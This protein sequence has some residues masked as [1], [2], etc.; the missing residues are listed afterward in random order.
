MDIPKEVK[1]IL[2][3][4]EKTKYEAFIVGGCVR[5]LIMKREPQDWDITTNAPPEEVKKIFP[6]SFYENKFG[7]VGVQ[8]KIGIIEITTFRTEEKYTDKRHPDEIKF[9]KTLKEDLARRD[10]TINA[11]AM[12]SGFQ[13]HDLFD[14]QKDLKNKVIRTVGDSDER[15][16]EDALRLLR[17]IRFTATLGFKIETKTFESIKKNIGLLRF[18]S[19]ERIRD[20]IIKII[21]TSQPSLGFELLRETGLLKFIMPEL[22]EGWGVGQNKHHIYTVWEHN[23]RSLAYGAKEQFS[24]LV[25]LAALLHDVGKPRAKEGDG[26]DSTFYGHDIIGAK[27]AAQIMENLKFPRADIEKV[28]KL[29][30]WHLFNYDP[31]KGIT[32]S[33]IRR[34]I[35]NVGEENI[36]DLVKVRMCDRIG[37]GVPKAVPYRLRHFEFRV[38]KILRE[39]EAVSVKMLKI[40]GNDVMKT[41]NIKA[42]PRIGHILNTILEE[43]I[44]NPK[45]NEHDYLIQRMAELN[46]MSDEKLEKLR[47]KAETKIELLENQREGEIKEKHYV[48]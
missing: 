25:K 19:K 40:N 24:T 7:T 38:E 34:L 18:I 9:A 2:E 36:E 37:S 10:F 22:G 33:A 43:V 31:E 16:Q 30:R 8:S 17:A 41:L 42:G 32:D 13:L 26:P 11:M 45:N 6:D 12:D 3:K 15:F 21:E 44:D 46:K 47:D 35:K 1:I 28:Y 27:I 29:I 48:K 20:E 4:L 39:K 23:I 14:G 5:D